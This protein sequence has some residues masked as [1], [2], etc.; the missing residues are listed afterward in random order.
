MIY[1]S[2]VQRYQLVSP[3]RRILYPH[4]NNRPLQETLIKER[5]PQAWA[6]LTR[7]R[8]LLAARGSLRRTGGRFFELIWPRD[9][10]WLRKPKLLIRDLAPRTAFA[11]DQQGNTF[12]VGGTAVV[13]EHSE[14]LL[15]LLA[16]LNSSVVNALVKRTTPQFR[17]DFQKFEPQH[18]QGIPVL[19]RIVL[20]PEF[21]ERLAHLANSVIAARLQERE[22]VAVEIEGSI[23]AIVSEAAQERGIA[24]E[25]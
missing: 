3:I 4:R 21:S 19:D 24:I 5:Y 25:A 15:P 6:Y 20:D 14:M 16:Y 12:I 11:L 8:D 10:S 17:G 2:E 13:P 7:N 9:E 23:D 18:I 1:G 22:S